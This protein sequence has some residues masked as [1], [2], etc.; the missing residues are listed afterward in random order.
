MGRALV[1]MKQLAELLGV[2]TETVRRAARSGL[3]P[4][5][6]EKTAYRFDLEQVCRAMRARA[7][8]RPYRQH[9]EASAP[10]GASRPR[11]G[12]SS[13]RTGNT[14]AQTTGI[15]PGGLEIR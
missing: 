15:V 2:S 8:S 1:T 13:P 4:S 3:I 12:S 10:G 7:E 5:T 6:R 9:Q 14:G 11:A